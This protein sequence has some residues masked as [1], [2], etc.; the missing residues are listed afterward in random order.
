MKNLYYRSSVLLMLSFFITTRVKAQQFISLAGKWSFNI[1]SAGTGE[2]ESRSAR[3]FNQAIMLP[4]TTDQVGIGSNYP[5]YKNEAGIK[6]PPDYPRDADFGMLT[7]I[8]KYVGRVWFQRE[9][10]IPGNWKDQHAELYLERVLW[11]SRVWIDGKPVSQ[12]VDY[13]NSPHIHDLGIIVPGLHTLTVEID[14]RE[15]YPVG[16]LGHDYDYHTQ[17]LWNGMVGRIGL[18]SKP[19]VSFKNVRIFPSRK[20]KNVK[21]EIALTNSGFKAPVTVSFVLVEKSSGKIAAKKS[22]HLVV[23]ADSSAIQTK[24]ILNKLPL[25]WDEFT[26]DLYTAT[27]VLKAGDR[28]YSYSADF[29]F[30]DISTQEKH[31]AVNGRRLFVRFSN[32]SMFF[33]QTGYPEMDLL[34]WKQVFSV[35]KAYGFNGI[36]FH[37]S[38]PPEAAFKA[39][40]QLGLY[41][42][43]EFFWMDDWMRLPA[44]MGGKNDSLNNFAR[45]EM[46]NAMDTY[47]NHPSMMLVL[48]GN[49]MGGDFTEMGKWLA[50]EKEYDPRHYFAVSTAHRVT[51]SDDF[52]EYGDKG[53]AG[54]LPGSN[55]DYELHFIEAGKHPYDRL[56]IRKDLPEFAHEAGQYI[57][58]PLWSEIG[59]Y[60]G[61]LSPRNL[62]YFRSKA[63]KSGIEGQDTVF[64]LASGKMN[65]ILYKAEIEAQLRTRSNAGYSLLSMAD[66]PGQGEAYIGWVNVFYKNKPF[67]SPGQYKLYG[68]HTVPLARLSKFVWSAGERL[69]APIEVANYGPAILKSA[70]LRYSFVNEDGKTVKSGL[71]PRKDIIQ[72]GITQVGSVRQVLAA[73]NKGSHLKL[74]LEILH[75]DFHNEWDLWVFPGKINIAI[76]KSIVFTSDLKE[77]LEALKQGKK[78]L[79]SASKAGVAG[80]KRYASFQPVF[81]S[82]TWF[83][84]QETEVSGAVI[85]DKNAAF[86][87]FP[88]KA[89]MDWQWFDLCK[90]AHG[91]DLDGL[92]LSYFPLV[93]PVDD[94]HFGKK[95]GSLFELVTEGGGKLMVCGYDITDSLDHCPATRQLRH[96][97]LDYMNSPAF[98]PSQQVTGDWLIKTFSIAV[99][100]LKGGTPVQ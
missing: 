91:F 62:E 76:P 86:H 61:A 67:M 16:I 21:F 34:Y 80:S 38:C 97:L 9:I 3:R 33:P 12:P 52:V 24:L 64:Q 8:H 19:P 63:K 6:P 26:P 78:V 30:R 14:N 11:R 5:I 17:T 94:Y 18:T 72:G 77:A 31:L 90:N 23:E 74:R 89:V 28:K 93:Q 4:G 22:I 75:T 7:R 69:E 29:G 32:E 46:R 55:W 15:L 42:Q 58:H 36:R 85:Q 70:V 35:Y 53:M 47:G 10:N 45:R 43:V 59:Q 100:D 98:N 73:E 1:D 96:S 71:L 40:D 84:G 48:F 81:W 88:T 82:A 66:Y 68:T 95:L 13:L 37:S 44:L 79:F 50:Q 65:A 60:K 39:A 20:H 2:G 49:E 25:P 83:E 54:I 57:V 87:D 92:P 27:I 99:P 56:F 51:A 41:L